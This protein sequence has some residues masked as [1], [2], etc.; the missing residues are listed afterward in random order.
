[1]TINCVAGNANAAGSTATITVGVGTSPVTITCTV[2]NA[3][4]SGASA[5]V[6]NQIGNVTITTSVGGALAQ[7]LTALVIMGSGGIGIGDRLEII[8]SNTNGRTDQINRVRGDTY[9]DQGV[10]SSKTNGL[11]V[12]LSGSTLTMTLS[13]VRNPADDSTQIYQLNGIMIDAVNGVVGFAP[14][15]QQSDI[16]G[17]FYYDV[18]LVDVSGIVRTLV[19]DVYVYE[20]DITKN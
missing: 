10:I 19:K 1:V 11:S 12:D 16:V 5:S 2:G 3:N 17:L 15:A 18:Q 7:G 4:A 20:E 8:W 9:A 13:S 14:N 6:D